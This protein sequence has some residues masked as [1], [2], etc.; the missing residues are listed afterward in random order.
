M[1][2]HACSQPLPSDPGP[3]AWNSILPAQSPYPELVG[4]KACD[5]LI[6]GAGFAG[7]AAA[8]RLKQHHP[9]DHVVILEA[10]QIA[11]GPAG[12]NS[13]FMIDLPHDLSTENY[14][15]GVEHDHEQILLNRAGI[16]FAGDM[17]A[18][19]NL[20]TEAYVKSG[21]TNAAATKKGVL[22]N[23]NYAA[24]L[25]KLGEKYEI[26]DAQAMKRLTGS[27]YYVGGLYTPG[28][29]IIQPAKYIRGIAKGLTGIGV[30][31]FEKSPA[32][33]LERN[34]GKWNAKTPNGS[35]KASNV[36]LAVN[37]H[38]ESFG[39]FK[40]RLVHVYLYASMTRAMN[41]NE[42][43][44]LGGKKIWGCTPSDPF[45]STVR[46]I[47][48]IGGDRIMV[49]NR[50]SYNPSIQSSTKQVRKFSRSHDKSFKVRFPMLDAL[51]M[52]YRWGGR[53]CLSWNTAPAFGE[54]EKNLFSACCQNG[55][56]TALG[57]SSGMLIA[58]LATGNTSNLLGI[59]QRQDSPRK[60]PSKPFSY[61]G[62]NAR[63]R[64]GELRAGREL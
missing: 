24:H 41:Q 32:T 13:G 23:I 14:G 1:N 44:S 60:I 30:C 6:I 45:G 34:N 57:T 62:V 8:Y 16:M 56:G 11:H 5:W 63:L 51:E 59:L 29:A 40:R 3:A 55:L 36:I 54:I 22:H 28:A 2:T 49:R 33:K 47:S 12:R 26:L 4:D 9:N 25:D 7:L 27:P 17:A 46:K 31:L 15:S 61:L 43:K 39:F 19:F 42:I 52:E 58:D 53:L 18:D 48:G 21:K 38:A 20:D 50:V 35:I 10:K 64:W 37:G